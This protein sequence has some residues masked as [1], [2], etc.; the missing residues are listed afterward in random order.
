LDPRTPPGGVWIRY[1]RPLPKAPARAHRRV[2]A[3]ASPTV[4]RFALAS[5]VLPLVTETVAVAELVRDALQARYGR[6]HGGAA[7]IVLSGKSRDGTPLRGHGH[8]HY[9]PADEDGD[10]RLDTLTVFAP[11]GFDAEGRAALTDLRE[12]RRQ[13]DPYPL[14]VLLLA[15]GDDSVGGPVLEGASVWVSATPFLLARHPKRGRDGPEDQLA[16]DLTR[17]G[18]SQPVRVERLAACDCGSHR[19]RWLEFRRWRRSGSGPA[20]G[21]GFGFR[22][23]FAEPVRG[24][25]TLGYGS[26]F[27]LG[28]FLPEGQRSVSASGGANT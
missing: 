13:S 2:V 26:H 17:R 3:E 21:S 24:P 12:L 15:L 27:G 1:A 7:S 28:L 18:L 19:F 20:V 16:L 6:L 9:L 10:G 25:I 11:M 8:A 4:A 5:K 22:L 14:R 23:T